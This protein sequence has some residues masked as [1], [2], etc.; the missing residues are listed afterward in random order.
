MEGGWPRLTHLELCSRFLPVW[1]SLV[2]SQ[3]P[4]D[5]SASEG[6]SIC[7]LSVLV[8]PPGLSCTS[9]SSDLSPVAPLSPSLTL[10]STLLRLTPTLSSPLLS[11]HPRPLPGLTIIYGVAQRPCPEVPALKPVPML[12]LAASRPS[13]QKSQL[14]PAPSSP[15]LSLLGMG[16]LSMGLP[17]ATLP[18]SGLFCSCS[19]ILAPS[20]APSSVAALSCTH[21][22][23]MRP[24]RCFWEPCPCQR[25]Y[26]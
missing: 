2:C 13:R 24:A 21:G 4:P 25:A 7:V 9:F 20:S 16:A 1:Q 12:Y 5:Y 6:L 14:R 18:E 22:L 17:L 23:Q 26:F 3:D 8:L 15:Q 19:T 10:S 11:E